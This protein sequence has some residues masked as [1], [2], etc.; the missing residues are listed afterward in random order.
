[1]Y[2]LFFNLILKT[3]VLILLLYYSSK[4]A[5]ALGGFVY[6]TFTQTLRIPYLGK[7]F[8]FVI[9][10]KVKLGILLKM[11]GWVISSS[12]LLLGV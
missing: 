5:A 11:I 10:G 12:G 8:N 4:F 6:M 9:N 1:M 3:V 2:E 7:V